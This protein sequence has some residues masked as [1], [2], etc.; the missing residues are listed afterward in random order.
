VLRS[1][2]YRSFAF[3]N[4]SQVQLD[5]I[6]AGAQRFNRMAGVIGAMLFDGARFL[7]YIEGPDDGVEGAIGRIRAS[8]DHSRLH[9]IGD[10]RV[11]A[12]RFPFWDMTCLMQP[13]TVLDR[14][15][16]APWGDQ[17]HAQSDSGEPVGGLLLLKQLL[18]E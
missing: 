18:A 7:Q 8:E 12:R 17:D 11:S 16:V 6:V 10:S 1:V 5:R 14:L 4:L 15:F 9:V 13:N 3:P 2:A